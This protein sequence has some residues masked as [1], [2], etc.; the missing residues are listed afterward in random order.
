MWDRAGDWSLEHLV[1][2]GQSGDPLAAA[3]I[4]RRF[5]PMACAVAA[6]SVPA[7]AVD[8][9]AQDAI[10][11]LLACLGELRQPFALPLL[12]RL[13]VRKHADRY[14]RGVR[15]HEEVDQVPP[16]E[17]FD[18][19]PAVL[20]ERRD[21][22][23]TVRAALHEAP[24]PDRQLLELRYLAEWSISDL[25]AATG[26]T[27]GA[28]RKRLFD[29]RRRLQSTLTASGLKP[30]TRRAPMPNLETFLGNTYLADGGAVDSQL[31]PLPARPR[32]AQRQSD[33]ELH[34]TQ[35]ERLHTGL[36]VIDSLA[37]LPRGGRI[38]IVGPFGTGHLVLVRE[39]V[40]RANRSTPTVCVA[41]GSRHWHKGGF[42]NFRKFGDAANPESTRFTT[43][44][45]S[46]AD[47][48]EAA[49]NL[50]ARL[51]Y[52]LV[53]DR[54]VIVAVDD[55]VATQTVSD[56]S[57]LRNGTTT[58]GRALTV[59]HVDPYGEGF[60]AEDRSG[61]DARIALSLDLA[62]RGLFPAID[63]EQS[64][65]A[66]LIGDGV[67]ATRAQQVRTLLATARELTAA[68]AEGL[69][70][71]PNERGEWIDEADAS[72][73]IDSLVAKAAMR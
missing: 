16:A 19:D 23:L 45:C 55:F 35:L 36:K 6:R 53:K 62:A 7:A 49:L 72:R 67:A 64:S 58:D 41:I 8:D 46:S 70:G 63:A 21:V 2:I 50:G 34:S 43:I 65:S 18:S 1:S 51:A 12:L 22:I 56:S 15:E 61:Y 33:V 26:L 14:R 44:L 11:E 54:D 9:V 47:D 52:A 59:L 30:T 20:A 37:P 31:E 5:R 60:Q 69:V 38:D 48:A 25:A 42:S 29:A 66:L 13:A 17:Q 40:A 4:V 57:S 3:E 28:L 10:L 73:E 32:L 27:E 39:L 68:L 24:E 71:Q